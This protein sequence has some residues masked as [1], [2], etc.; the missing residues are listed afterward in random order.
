MKYLLILILLI[1]ATSSAI[2][3]D[4]RGH[5]KAGLIIGFTITLGTKKPKY[6]FMTGCAVGLAKESYDATGRGT[7]EFADFAATCAGAGVSSWLLGK[8]LK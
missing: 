4:K 5:F 6:G 3:K 8:V 7:V 2:D 1:P